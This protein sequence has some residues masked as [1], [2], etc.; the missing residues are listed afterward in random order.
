MADTA[1]LQNCRSS[2]SGRGAS[3]E[4]G[5]GESDL[6]LVMLLLLIILRENR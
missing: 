4:K 5:G 2:Y 1:H 3:P 6:M